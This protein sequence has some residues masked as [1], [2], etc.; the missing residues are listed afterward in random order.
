MSSKTRIIVLR[1][2]EI[3]YTAI[4]IGFAIL[5]ILL[6]LFMFR[7]EDGKKETETAPEAAATYTPGLYSASIVLGSQNVNVEVAV[8]ADRINSITL[9]PLSD[10][11]AAMYPLMQPS[12]D[13]LAEQIISSQSLQGIE[14]PSGSQYTSTALMSAIRTALSKAEK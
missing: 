5:L 6:F 12:M 8:D 3:I 9:V 11:V 4:F 14:Y 1:M 13:S 2:K 7:P 10:T